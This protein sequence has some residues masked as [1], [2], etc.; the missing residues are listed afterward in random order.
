MEGQEAP[1]RKSARWYETAELARCGGYRQRIITKKNIK[2]E[3]K[4]KNK[5]REDYKDMFDLRIIQQSMWMWR[6]E[7]SEVGLAVGL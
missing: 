7:Y 3:F 2:R 4:N 6:R 1:S 5:K